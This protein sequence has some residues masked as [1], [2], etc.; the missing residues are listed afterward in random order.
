M[1]RSYSTKPMSRV[2]CWIY[3]PFN[4]HSPRHIISVGMGLLRSMPRSRQSCQSLSTLRRKIPSV[5][6]QISGQ[7]LFQNEP[8]M[9]R[10]WRRRTGLAWNPL[11]LHVRHVS[12]LLCTCMYPQVTRKLDPVAVFE[13]GFFW[14]RKERLRVNHEGQVREPGSAK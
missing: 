12:I 10:P 13:Q 5:G 9:C 4:V 2:V 3:V 14:A 6:E 7:E 11:R 8:S 1:S